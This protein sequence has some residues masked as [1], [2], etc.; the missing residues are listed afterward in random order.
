[1]KERPVP[2]SQTPRRSPEPPGFNSRVCTAQIST[3]FAQP[4][5]SEAAFQQRVLEYARLMHW[6]LAHFRPAR[7]ERGWRTPMAGD[8]GFPDL[9]LL[10]RDRLVFAE[11]K[12]DSGRLRPEQL[13][14][15][16]S[17]RRTCNE[18][19]V[20]RPQDWPQIVEALR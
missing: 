13:Q 14:W 15:L 11:L 2:S 20:W 9:V 6:R 17:L 8:P 18:V 5:I 10:R 7:T 4:Q 12:T 16:E 19:Y 3:G 1:M